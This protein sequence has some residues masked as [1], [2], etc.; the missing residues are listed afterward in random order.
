MHP[1]LPDDNRPHLIGDDVLRDASICI[2]ITVKDGEHDIAIMRN[3]D[4]RTIPPETLT[5]LVSE[6]AE[7]LKRNHP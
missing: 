6:L 2:A 5:R 4:R 7:T 1:P 3:Q